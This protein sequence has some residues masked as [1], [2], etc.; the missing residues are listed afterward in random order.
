[1]G[2]MMWG[3]LAVIMICGLASESGAEIL[4]EEDFSDGTADGFTEDCDLWSVTPSG[5][6]TID[7][8]G[9]EVFAWSFIGNSAW[10]DYTFSL[11]VS[12]KDS[13]NHIA[14]VRVQKNGDCYLVNMRSR[15]FND[16]V[17]TKYTGGEFHNLLFMPATVVGQWQKMAVSVVG[18]T[19]TA[20]ENG[21]VLFSYSDT[22][23]PLLKGGAAVVALAGGLVLHQEL[24]LDN[25]LVESLEGKSIVSTEQTTW[26]HLK[27]LYR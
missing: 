27:A 20:S 26:S 4:F 14:A 10:T 3:L 24:F 9:Y 1:M 6:Y 11:D 8:Y 12:S 7:I 21:S 15:P 13:K 25:I 22:D 2:K 23:K 19:I 17:L 5:W 18:S 16:I